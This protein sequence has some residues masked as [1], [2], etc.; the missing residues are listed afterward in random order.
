[1]ADP[2][3]RARRWLENKV[4]ILDT[5]TTGL[6]DDAE[7]CEISV[8]DTEGNVLFDEVVRPTVPIG[9]KAM[10]VHGIRNMDIK[11]HPSFADIYDRLK[12]IIEGRD[13]VV[14]NASYDERL[15]A[16]SAEAHGLEAIS[17]RFDCAMLAYAEWY[18]EPSHKERGAYRWQKLEK[19]AAQNG[20][21][22]TQP[23]HRALS[24]CRTT[25]DVIRA[26]AKGGE[27]PKGSSGSSAQGRESWERDQATRRGCVRIFLFALLLLVLLAV[28]VW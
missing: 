11:N 25:L 28:L 22:P 12:A 23:A 13:V 2:T 9:R 8:I 17:A 26:M 18:G 21:T 10:Q 14:Y 4:L 27:A 3:Q 24:D 16:Q 1:M 5:E 20:I 15:L 6:G 7:V 19:A